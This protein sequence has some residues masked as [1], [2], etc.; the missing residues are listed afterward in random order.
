MDWG[1]ESL[2]KGYLSWSS[3][4]SYFG[5]PGAINASQLLTNPRQSNSPNDYVRQRASQVQVGLSYELNDN[6]KIEKRF[7]NQN[8]EVKENFP[9]WLW[10]TEKDYQNFSY[11]PSL[12]YNSDS[13]DWTL[14]FDF[15]EDELK[16]SNNSEYKRST[17]AFFT[18][19]GLDISEQWNFIGNFRLERAENSLDFKENKN[20]WAGSVG[21][22]RELSGQNRAYGT[23]RR[24][25]RYPALDEYTL[26]IGRLQPE[27]GYETELG[28][29]WVIDDAIFNTRIFRQWMNDELILDPNA[30]GTFGQ[31]VNLPK[32]QALGF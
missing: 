17:T 24:F 4:N 21:L 28:L 23:V 13:I 14:G 16:N 11:C 6:W 1:G 29:D 22:I 20:E 19:A 12:H 3:S 27:S 7:G 31:N 26:S 2:L 10:V 8:R 18:S 32:N 30:G 25:Y 15:T 5:L 9:D